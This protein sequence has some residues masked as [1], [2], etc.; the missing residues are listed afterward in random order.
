MRF[1]FEVCFLKFL[2]FRD[3]MMKTLAIIKKLKKEE[4]EEER[5]SS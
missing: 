4:E 1:D 3:V 5:K 2:G